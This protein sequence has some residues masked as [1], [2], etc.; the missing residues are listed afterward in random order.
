MLRDLKSL[1]FL[2]QNKSRYSNARIG[3]GSRVIDSTFDGADVEI[4]KDCYIQRCKFGTG[5]IVKD[6]SA[7]FDSSFEN[8]S[9]VY[10][11]CSLSNV[12]FGAY[13]YVNEHSMMSGVSVGRFTCVGPYFI[14]G[15]GDHP[16]DFITTSPVFYS[17]R[18]QC[19]VSF[20]ETSRYDEKRQ[21]TL[22]N[23]VWIGARVFV[24][25]GVTIGSG[26]LIAAGAVV[27]NDVP[28]YAIVGGVPAKL[29]RYRF[30][31][32]VVAQLLDLQWWNW[33][34][35][36]LR[37]AQPYLSQADVNSFLEWTKRNVDSKNNR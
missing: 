13:S 10:P 32:D 17:T 4:G 37:E 19:G 1:I 29:I 12:K 2:L 24:R 25:D 28:E 14:C 7:I 21:T 35:E 26:A 9:A 6:H 31:D 5:A 11:H 27:A 20:T 34:E 16:T 36:R 15:Y 22:G 30:A 8:N 33:S 18:R 23:D 3:F